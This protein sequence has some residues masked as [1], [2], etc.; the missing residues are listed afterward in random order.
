MIILNFE[1]PAFLLLMCLFLYKMRV[2]VDGSFQIVLCS[3]LIAL[4]K[5]SPQVS[6]LR[7]D[8]PGK[9]G[10]VGITSPGARDGVSDLQS[11]AHA[12]S[13]SLP[14]SLAC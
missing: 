5:T 1:I 3:L 8:M 12:L 9:C 7:C 11:H 4:I 14:F 13:L 6:F 10:C 2:T